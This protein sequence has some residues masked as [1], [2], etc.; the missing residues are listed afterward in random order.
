MLE[1]GGS[2]QAFPDNGRKQETKELFWM[3]NGI[4]QD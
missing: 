1:F 3:L 2:R 4:W